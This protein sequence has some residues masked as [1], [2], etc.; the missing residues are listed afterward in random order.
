MFS[1]AAAAATMLREHFIFI[2]GI[3]R[4]MHDIPSVLLLLNRVHT[5]VQTIRKHFPIFLLL[6]LLFVSLVVRLVGCCYFLWLFSWL[7]GMCLG[8]RWNICTQ[9]TSTYSRSHASTHMLHLP[10]FKLLCCLMF[11]YFRC[12]C[13]CAAQK[14]YFVSSSCLLRTLIRCF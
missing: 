3:E 14:T 7:V 8:E 6:L 5:K 2:D 1:I 12:V 10:I 13:V 9:N 11:T 4:S